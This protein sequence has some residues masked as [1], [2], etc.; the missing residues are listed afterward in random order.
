MRWLISDNVLLGHIKNR[1]KFAQVVQSLS[2]TTPSLFSESYLFLARTT[3]PIWSTRQVKIYFWAEGRR[4]LKRQ[5]DC[6]IPNPENHSESQFVSVL[7]S[8]MFLVT[9][10]KPLLM[11]MQYDQPLIILIISSQLFFWVKPIDFILLD[12]ELHK[13]ICALYVQTN[14]KFVITCIIF[15]IFI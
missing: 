8:P 1:K 14:R 6:W 11:Y 13:K 12:Y 15:F 7:F 5:K 4:K 3:T 10:G 2:F 9:N